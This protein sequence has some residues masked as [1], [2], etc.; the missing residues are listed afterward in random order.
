MGAASLAV[1][2]SPAAAATPGSRCWTDIT[3][4]YAIAVSLPGTVSP[5]G[6]FCGVGTQPPPFDVLN[7]LPCG[8]YTGALL[9]GYLIQVRCPS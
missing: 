7:V 2:S 5:D 3:G 1:G 8:T 4:G 6:N 9:P